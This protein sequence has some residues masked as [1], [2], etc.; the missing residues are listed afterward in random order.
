MKEEKNAIIDDFDEK[1]EVKNETSLN[2]WLPKEVG[3]TI[4]GVVKQIE[5]GMFDGR[6]IGL[7]TNPNS[8]DLTFLP[9]QSFLNSSLKDVE[10]GQK[11]KIVYTGQTKSQNGRLYNTY[12]VF[13][14]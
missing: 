12:K 2:V 9:E 11:V 14:K 4:I 3:D 10:V 1:D 8:E 7:Q 13:I 5:A 6:K